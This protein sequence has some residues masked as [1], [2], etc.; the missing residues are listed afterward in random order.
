MRQYL[1]QTSRKEAASARLS[2]HCKQV[3]VLYKIYEIALSPTAMVN[4]YSVTNKY[5]NIAEQVDR[6]VPVTCQ[7]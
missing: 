7:T 4:L 2:L 5:G 3:F 6:R 1:L